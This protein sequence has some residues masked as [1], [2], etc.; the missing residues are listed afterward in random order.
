MLIY[1]NKKNEL[2]F[3]LCR[4]EL[5]LRDPKILVFTVAVMNIVAVVAAD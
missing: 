4:E 3:K 5:P 2:K 1:R